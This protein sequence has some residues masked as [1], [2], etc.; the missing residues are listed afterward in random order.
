MRPR[1]SRYISDMCLKRD[2]RDDADYPRDGSL[3]DLRIGFQGNH[4]GGDLDYQT[5]DLSYSKYLSLGPRQVLALRGVL[6]R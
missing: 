6:H 5:Y 3:F 4:A 2:S 1:A